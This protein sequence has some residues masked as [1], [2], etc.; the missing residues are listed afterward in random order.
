M[1]SESKRKHCFYEDRLIGGQVHIAFDFDGT[2]TPQSHFP[3]LGDPFQWVEP[4]FRTLH[5][6]GCKVWVYSA[7]FNNDFYGSQAD[8]W[9]HECS[10]WLKEHGLWQYVTLT[11]YK[12]PADIIFDDRGQKLEGKKPEDLRHAMALINVFRLKSGKLLEFPKELYEMT[13]E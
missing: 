8:I 11:K 1:S 3:G 13:R 6:Q 7:R 4:M 12:P 9:F 5:E 10:E 2:L